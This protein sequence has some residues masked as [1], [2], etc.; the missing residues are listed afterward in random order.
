MLQKRERHLENQMA[1]QQEIAK[2]NALTN[3][4]GTLC[5][6]TVAV[7]NVEVGAFKAVSSFQETL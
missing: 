7:G 1:K 5:R 6:Q 2:E 4:T 3:K